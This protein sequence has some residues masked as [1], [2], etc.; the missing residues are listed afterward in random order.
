MGALD[1]KFSR[2]LRNPLGLMYIAAP[3]ILASFGRIA[4]M[5]S[6]MSRF[7]LSGETRATPMF[8][9]CVPEF[10]ANRDPLRAVGMPMSVMMDCISG[11]F[12]WRTFSISWQRSVDSS[13]RV[14]TGSFTVM[15]NCPSSCSGKNSVPMNLK[16]RR[17]TAPTTTI[18]AITERRCCSV[19][20]SHFSYQLSIPS[21]ASWA[22]TRILS[23]SAVDS[24]SRCFSGG[25]NLRHISG[26]TVR[27][28][29]NEPKSATPMVI[30]SGMKRSFAIPVR[31]TIGRKTMTVVSV[32]TNMGEATSWAA[33]SVA[34]I[35]VWLGFRSL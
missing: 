3:G 12:A 31:K 14:P 9:A 8:A 1:P 26:V 35:F 18:P 5:I 4:L 34:C 19:H 27:D 17:E 28:T 15:E 20:P 21:S 23:G 11:M 22:L 24:L 32:E 33:S 16:S 6:N 2:N 10:L 29:K 25:R 13:I 30:V 7:R